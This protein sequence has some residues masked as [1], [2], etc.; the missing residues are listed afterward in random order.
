MV[1]YSESMQSKI[2]KG[3]DTWGEVQWKPG[4]SFQEFPSSGISQDM[5]NLPAVNCDKLVRCLPGKKL[6]RDL[7]PKVITRGQSLKVPSAQ[8]VPRF[9]IPKRKQMFSIDDIVYTAVQTFCQHRLDFFCLEFHEWSY[10][11]CVLLSLASFI[12]QNAFEIHPCC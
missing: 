9:Q 3:K 8:P 12:L 7:V 1:Y 10:V 2:D 4:T 5:L 6:T 11:V